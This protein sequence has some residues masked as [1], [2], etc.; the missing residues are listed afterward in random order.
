MSKPPVP[1]APTLEETPPGE[2]ES[3]LCSR[4]VGCGAIVCKL[5]CPPPCAVLTP[6]CASCTSSSRVRPSPS[7]PPLPPPD[8]C[9]CPFLSRC[10][11]YS[12]F[13]SLQL[14]LERRVFGT[15]Q[16]PSCL[17]GLDRTRDNK[18]G[19]VGSGGRRKAAVI[20]GAQSSTAGA[21][22]SLRMPS[23]TR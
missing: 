6:C 5:L 8:V 11:C 23:P 9:I 12:T 2:G 13:H 3:T 16:C 4:A 15:Q 7:P 18:I 20:L 1:L 17:W 21:G 10:S 14:P 22:P 19:G